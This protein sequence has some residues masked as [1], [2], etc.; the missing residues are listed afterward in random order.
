LTGHFLGEIV[1]KTECYIAG[2]N[3]DSHWSMEAGMMHLRYGR[4]AIAAFAA[5]VLG[6]LALI[7]LVMIFGPPG[8]AAAQPFV[9]RLGA[10]VGP[11]SGFV[12][13]ILGGFWVA[14]GA[15]SHCMINGVS[16][17]IAA[18]ALDFLTATAIG[19]QF[20]VLFLL[21]N[22]GRVVGSMVGGWLAFR[23]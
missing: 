23:N 16:M 7:I 22:A 4:I 11:I 6:I 9:E 13:R 1:S 17:G 19:G 21:S 5:E 14:K 15:E 8:F 18:A 10:W 3:I 2:I 20:Q 12:V